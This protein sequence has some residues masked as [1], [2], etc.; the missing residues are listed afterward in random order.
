MILAGFGT[1]L[2]ALLFWYELSFGDVKGQ[3]LIKVVCAASLLTVLGFQLIFSS[4]FLSLLGERGEQRDYP[5]ALTPSPPATVGL[6]A[7]RRTG[8]E[9]STR[10]S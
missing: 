7:N 6:A 3:H 5:P 8:S 10:I 4:F 2:Y 1:A 9:L